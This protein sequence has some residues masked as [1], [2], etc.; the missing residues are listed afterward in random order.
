MADLNTS[1]NDRAI[2]SSLK[3][4]LTMHR[5]RYRAAGKPSLRAPDDLVRFVSLVAADVAY[6][7]SAESP[8]YNAKP[9]TDH[10]QTKKS[11]PWAIE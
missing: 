9:I 4:R 5:W 6:Y 3:R 2:T 1:G 11:D 8:E 10:S 7:S